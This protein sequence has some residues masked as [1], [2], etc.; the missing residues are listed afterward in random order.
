[1][2]Y[3]LCDTNQE[4]CKEWILAFK[5][6]EDVAVIS[7]SIFDLKV[8]A[9]VSPA[10]SFG[11][12]DGGLDYLISENMGWDIEKNLQQKINDEYNGELL[13]GQACVIPTTHTIPFVISAPTMR[14]PMFIDRKSINVY[15][16]SKAIFNCVNNW[17]ATNEQQINTVAIPG[18]GTGTGRVPYDIC[19]KQ[20]LK[21]YL[22][23]KYPVR[24][25]SLKEVTD[26]HY[27]LQQ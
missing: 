19:A 1:M 25:I 6:V 14:V 5:D 3:I 21:A 23:V 22:D 20:M 18:L 4:L 27:F 24:T 16:A 13:V 2:K 10:N 7:G 9:L 11:F 12:M 26:R 15:L 17:N 8:D